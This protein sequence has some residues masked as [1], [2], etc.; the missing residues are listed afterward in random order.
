MV[1][2]IF[3]DSCSLGLRTPAGFSKWKKV[4]GGNWKIAGA[5]MRRASGTGRQ[6]RQWGG[7]GRGF[8][9]PAGGVWGASPRK[10]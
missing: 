6:S 5:P 2:V 7:C 1:G 3:S 8:P 9:P 4:S 10:N